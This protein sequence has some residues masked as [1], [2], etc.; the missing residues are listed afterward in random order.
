MTSHVARLYAVA[1]A[2][3]VFFVG[4]AGIAAHPWTAPKPDPAVA[5]LAVREQRIQAESVAVKQL[6]DKRWNAYRIALAARQTAI[7]ARKQQLATATAPAPAAS[8]GVR[9]VTLPPL[10]VTRTS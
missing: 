3:V 5:A 7:A 10:T 4:W 9:V 1:G 8:P 6:L 2:L